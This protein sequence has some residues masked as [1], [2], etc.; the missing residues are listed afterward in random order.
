MKGDRRTWEK[1]A[2]QLSPF[3][4]DRSDNKRPS[5]PIGD[6]EVT[7]E[8]RVTTGGKEYGIRQQV[9]N[10]HPHPSMRAVYSERVLETIGHELRLALKVAD[11]SPVPLTQEELRRFYQ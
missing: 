7:I 4:K 9:K 1:P 6:E 2:E 3:Q 11:V 5:I 10:L 8:V